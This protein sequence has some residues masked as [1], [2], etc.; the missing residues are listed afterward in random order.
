MTISRILRAGIALA[1]AGLIAAPA[2]GQGQPVTIRVGHGSAAEDQLWLMKAKPDITPGQGK[3]Y[4]LDFTLFRGTD[5]RYQAFEAGQLDMTTGTGHTALFA[6]SQGM[7]FK[8]VAGLSRESSKGF[9]TQYMVMDNSPIKS[10]RD[11]KGKNVGNNAAR[12]SIELWQRIAFEKYLL[13]LFQKKA[14]PPS[15]KRS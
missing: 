1:T 14:K 2:L 6:A 5:T 3:V 15:M 7:K 13:I 12:S 9:H 11:L 8:I 10:I 4:K